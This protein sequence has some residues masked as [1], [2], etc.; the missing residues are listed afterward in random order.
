M[1][2]YKRLTTKC[3]EGNKPMTHG[4]DKEYCFYPEICETNRVCLECQYCIY[5]DLI[6]E[7]IAKKEEL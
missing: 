2:E 4:C 1:S 6:K 7:E 5:T 3:E